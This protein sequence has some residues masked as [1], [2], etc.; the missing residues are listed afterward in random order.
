MKS[1]VKCVIAC[2]ALLWAGTAWA[3]SSLTHLEVLGDATSQTRYMTLEC[4]QNCGSLDETYW[5]AT[6]NTWSSDAVYNATT[7]E[8]GTG[9]DQ[10]YV[11]ADTDLAASAN[12]PPAG[13]ILKAKLWDSNTAGGTL[14]GL[15]TFCFQCSKDRARLYRALPIE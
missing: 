7:E 8:G 4:S 14:E 10:T 13:A 5:D 1:A 2:A 11:L 12:K 15:A 9:T 6:N 3:G